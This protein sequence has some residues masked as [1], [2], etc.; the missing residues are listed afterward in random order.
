MAAAADTSRCS[1]RGTSATGGDED[2]AALEDYLEPSLDR[3]AAR[4]RRALDR[5]TLVP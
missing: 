5:I 1:S 2:A 3:R 4:R